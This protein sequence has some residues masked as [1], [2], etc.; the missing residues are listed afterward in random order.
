[1]NLPTLPKHDH[2]F[3]DPDGDEPD[4]RVW[5]KESMLAY[6]QAAAAAERE[7]WQRAAALMLVARSGQVTDMQLAERWAGIIAEDREKRA[8]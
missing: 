3:A 7:A 8:P 5:N 6:A 1:M 2:V 4:L